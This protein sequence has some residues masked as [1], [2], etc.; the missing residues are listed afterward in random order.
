M[1]NFDQIF[2]K[3]SGL[4]AGLEKI[5]S[6]NQNLKLRIG[7]S[8]IA[9][10]PA[11]PASGTNRRHIYYINVQNTS[12]N[13]YAKQVL[14]ADID[15]QKHLAT[16]KELILQSPSGL[17]FRH[18]SPDNS[19]PEIKNFL[20]RFGRL[21]QEIKS[22]ARSRGIEYSDSILQTPMESYFSTFNRIYSF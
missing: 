19:S 13:Y 12:K 20:S 8:G 15:S 3:E 17:Y 2:D 14:F 6:E 7:G 21:S 18:F 1:E 22:F 4:L 11:D 10:C 16:D 9:Y 5:L